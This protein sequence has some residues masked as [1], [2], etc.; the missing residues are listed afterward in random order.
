[1][2]SANDVANFLHKLEGLILIFESVDPDPLSLRQRNRLGAWV[3]LLRSGS[4]GGK[5]RTSKHVRRN[6]VNFASKII[7]VANSETL[8]LCLLVY[9]ISGL[10]KITHVNFYGKLKLWSRQRR[11]P[12]RLSDE[13]SKLWDEASLS[14]FVSPGDDRREHED[15]NPSRN[16]RVDASPCRT[17][18]IRGKRYSQECVDAK[19]TPIETKVLL[20]R[21]M[22]I[23]RSKEK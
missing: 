18:S 23:T 20:R 19:L 21:C 11:F 22:S 17:P 2:D 8:F 10:P 7:N 6:A 14:R 12:Q 15:T 1:M 9:S 16:A 4:P 13:A 5:S 3:A